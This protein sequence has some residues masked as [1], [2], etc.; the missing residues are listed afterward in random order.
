MNRT[1][2][3]MILLL[4]GMVLAA[5]SVTVRLDAAKELGPVNRMV[6][7]HNLEAADGRGIFWPQSDKDFD[8]FGTSFGQGVWNPAGHC[9]N[10]LFTGILKELHTGSLRYPGG[11]LNHNFDWRKAVGPAAERKGW[12]FGVNE[13]LT[14]CREI[15]A[16]PDGKSC[17][18]FLCRCPDGGAYLTL[19]REAEADEETCASDG[20]P[21]GEWERLWGAEACRISPE[22][23][24]SGLPRASF[25]FFRRL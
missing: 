22:G 11:C 16:E 23:V 5:E 14:V 12:E 24:V 8:R 21:R 1:I 9:S 17:T 4:A 18:G 25:A 10:P 2:G 13:Y 15:G 6:L 19:F 7:G 3:S 20:L